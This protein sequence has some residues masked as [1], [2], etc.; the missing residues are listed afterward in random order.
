MGLVIGWKIFRH[1][2]RKLI[3]VKWKNGVRS[4]HFLRYSDQHVLM[5]KGT[6]KNY[7]LKG[8]LTTYSAD[9]FA[10]VT[11]EGASK[12]AKAKMNKRKLKKEA[13]AKPVKRVKKTRFRD[14]IK[15]GFR[16]KKSGS[17][18]KSKPENP[19]PLQPQN[20]NII[21]QDPPVLEPTPQLS[22]GSVVD[23]NVLPIIPQ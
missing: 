6:Y 11:N 13:K 18:N 16:S 5:Q 14:F 17:K 19:S 3:A 4:G 15:K 8:K 10:N 21:P 1:W 7:K 9:G 23:P 2:L 22:P 12:S 20:T